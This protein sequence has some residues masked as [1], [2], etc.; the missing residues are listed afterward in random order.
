MT[1]DFEELQRCYR[2][3]AI[4][5]E[6]IS[7]PKKAKKGHDEL[8]AC[9]KRLRQSEAGRRAIMDL[10]NDAEPSV[11]LWAAAH[12]LQWAPNE[13]RRVLESLKDAQG[14]CSFTAEITLVEFDKGRLSFDY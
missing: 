5:T 3:G 6:H 14:R 11:R 12:S 2:E 9:Y 4:A 13:A 8:H 10:M 1:S 7:T